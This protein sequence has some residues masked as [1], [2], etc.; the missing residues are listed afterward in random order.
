MTSNW[1]IIS[2]ISCLFSFPNE[3]KTIGAKFDSSGKRLLCSQQEI[4]QLVV[5]DLPTL[6]HPIVNGNIV[7]TAP[8]FSR[9]Y[10]MDPI[11]FA[12][13]ND[14]LVVSASD[15]KNEL[16]IWALP[17]GRCQQDRTV[18]QSLQVLQ[19]HNNVICSVGYSNEGS[20]IISGDA[21]GI[22]KLWT[23]GVPLHPATWETTVDCNISLCS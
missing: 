6:Q 5:Y 4:S 15:K 8:D 12:G 16:M 1:R 22:I 21:D 19:G 14:E 7:L 23:P 18:D 2:H 9:K 13:L 11:V 10:W 17:D 20:A 3:N